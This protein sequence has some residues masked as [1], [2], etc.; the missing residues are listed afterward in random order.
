MLSREDT[1]ERLTAIRDRAR[2]VLNHEDADRQAAVEMIDTEL[3][4]VLEGLTTEERTGLELMIEL[5]LP[6]VRTR[7]AGDSRSGDYC[8]KCQNCTD[9]QCPVGILNPAHGCHCN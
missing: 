9:P 8:P 4:T 5:V 3:T 2:V 1:I 7:P 6:V